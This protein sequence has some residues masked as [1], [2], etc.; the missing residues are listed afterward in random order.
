MKRS[1]V[2]AAVG[3]ALCA[4]SS[5]AIA[6]GFALLNQN[7]S[8][9]GN[10]FAGGAAAAE[11]A[12]TIFFNPAGLTYIPGRQV[13]FSA[14][15]VR[16][17]VKFENT[18]STPPLLPP[19]STLGGS[20]GDAGGWALMPAS[21]LSWQISPALY[22]GMGFNAPYGLKTDYEQGWMGRYYALKSES[23]SMNLN[24]TIAIKVNDA[25]SAGFGVSYQRFETEL[26][27]S[28]NYAAIAAGGCV[29]QP[30]CIGPA[31]AAVGAQTEG[32]ARLE[33]DDGAWGYNLGIMLNVS[34]QTR[35]GLA[36]R[37]SIKHEI[38]GSA[39][40]SNRPAA[41]AAVVPDGPIRSTLKLP[42]SFSAAL[43]HQ[44]NPSWQVLMD[45]TW[46]DWSTL[47][48]VDAIRADTGAVLNS[49]AFRW[50]DTW[51]V[52]L[53]VNYRV[54]EAWT[55]RLGTVYEQT[56]TNN[57]DRDPRLPDPDRRWLAIGA[58]Y[59]LSKQG[60]ID[61]GF[62]HGAQTTGINLAPPNVSATTAATNGQLVGTVDNRVDIFAIQ[63]R[64]NF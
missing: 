35:V 47:N 12:S 25:L 18:A 22:L 52:G 28:I 49:L 38:S 61:F 45:V 40:F 57:T 13:V 32:I 3:A 16:S 46:T 53:G 55:L 63:Y 10:S 29:P 58:Q 59:R 11:D 33:G 41:L 26:T 21:Y 19:G 51:R 31:L 30:F 15:F 8:G 56:P 9:I 50:R 1:V 43:A 14:N 2:A 54:N 20:G 42:S 39:T 7:A 36:Y 44:F 23:K 6:T 37:S 64:H 24:P 5:Q 27:N 34:P 4:L 48:V 60:A 62:V 17:S